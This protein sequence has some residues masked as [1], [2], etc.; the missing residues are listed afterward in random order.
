LPA[1]I[2]DVA[3]QDVSVPVTDGAGGI[4][5]ILFLEGGEP[6]GPQGPNAF[7][8]LVYATFWIET[9]TPPDRDRFLQ[10]EVQDHVRADRR[11]ARENGSTAAALRP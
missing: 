8:S 11:G 6:A 3:M 5:N 1:S 2:E 9:V 7:T 10:L 4:E